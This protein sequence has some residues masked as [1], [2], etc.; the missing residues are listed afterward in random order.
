MISGTA[1]LRTAGSLL[2]TVA[3]RA[4]RTGSPRR[5]EVQEDH[6]RF[7]VG[8]TRPG[9]VHQ[10]SG[11]RAGVDDRPHVGPDPRTDLTTRAALDAGSTEII[12]GVCA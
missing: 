5:S 1:L 8:E 6:E 3:G 7:V 10:R 2:A 12:P 9:A 11:A 4:T